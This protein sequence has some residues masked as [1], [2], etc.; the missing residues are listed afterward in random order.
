MQKIYILTYNV[1]IRKKCLEQKLLTTLLILTGETELHS[2]DMQEMQELP[3]MFRL[4]LMAKKS[5]LNQATHKN[6]Y[7]IFLSKKSE[8]K[9]FQTKKNPSIISVT[10][11]PGY[12]LDS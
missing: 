4:F 9:K 7:Q 2:W 11:N 1:I 3:W 5:L 10:W 12:P 6:T 8:N